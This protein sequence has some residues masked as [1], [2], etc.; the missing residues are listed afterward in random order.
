VRFESTSQV[1][2]EALERLKGSRLALLGFGAENRALGRFLQTHG[3]DF[4]VCDGR[5][6][7]AI[8][9]RTEWNQCVSSWRLGPRYLESLEDFDWIFRTPGI[10]TR[11]PEIEAARSNGIRVSSQTQLFFDLCPASVIGVTGTKGKGTT[12]ALLADILGADG[13]VNTHLGG[14]IGVPPIGFLEDVAP[15]DR[16]ILELSSFQLH[17]LQSS[18]QTAVILGI[19][20]DH[21]DYHADVDE[22][23]EAKRSICR[24]QRSEDYLIAARENQSARQLA[25]S[26]P[27]H[28]VWF[29][30][31]AKVESGAWVEG[32]TLL[33][34]RYQEAAELCRRSELALAGDHN[35]NNCLAA[36]ATASIL[37]ASIG[38][39]ADSLRSFPGLPHR[40]QPIGTRNGIVYVDDSAATTPEAAAAAVRCFGAPVNLIAGGSGKGSDFAVLGA[41]VAAGNV[42][43][44]LLMGD[45]TE[46]IVRALKESAVGSNL[47]LERGD[48]MEWAVAAAERFAREGDVILLSPGC[49]SFGMFVNY[50]DR[51]Q[52]F[53]TYARFD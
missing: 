18:P 24:F 32:D 8:G 5:D 23:L 9:D 6:A 3:F 28:K 53:K 43:A 11:N 7:D 45:E 49:A 19:T 27:A 1:M 29:S 12:A 50:E 41:A 52:Q 31:V 42:R 13:N 17:D 26:S 46:S 14:N 34:R 40:L 20:Q 48:S 16:V 21:L 44:V 22:Y 15:G 37:G 4:A 33:V 51:A 39:I 2:T 30:T 36:A 25:D 38:S 47:V 35:L 10:N